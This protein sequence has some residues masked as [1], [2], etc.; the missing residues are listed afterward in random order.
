[1][2]KRP[3]DRGR[4]PTC[5][6]FS[7][8]C[9]GRRSTTTFNPGLDVS[10]INPTTSLKSFGTSL[11]HPSSTFT[12]K[13]LQRK[14]KTFFTHWVNSARFDH[15]TPSMNFHIYRFT[16]SH[17]YRE[18]EREKKH[19]DYVLDERL[20][21]HEATRELLDSIQ[22]KYPD[23]YIQEECEAAGKH[24]DEQ[25]EEDKKRFKHLIPRDRG[26]KAGSN[27]THRKKAK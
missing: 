21:M 25:V 13:W 20:K 2:L 23:I 26:K 22:E 3:S 1:M 27:G 4:S 18:R 12:T 7:D 10:R 24:Y 11:V 8:P 6:G 5:V 17:S 16:W 9:T 19:W 14:I 15:Y